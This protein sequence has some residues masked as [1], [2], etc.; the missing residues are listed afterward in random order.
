MSCHALRFRFVRKHN[1]PSHFAPCKV[2]QQTPN[3]I[4]SIRL[5]RYYGEQYCDEDQFDDVE[6]DSKVP[7]VSIGRWHV[8]VTVDPDTFGAGILTVHDFRAR[9]GNGH[10]ARVFTRVFH[11]QPRGDM[12]GVVDGA[13]LLRTIRAAWAQCTCT[14]P[15]VVG[16]TGTIDVYVENGHARGSFLAGRNVGIALGVVDAWVETWP[17]CDQTASVRARNAHVALLSPNQWVSGLFGSPA[18]TKDERVTYCGARAPEEVRAALVSCRS[19][20]QR[21]AIADSW[22]MLLYAMHRVH[23]EARARAFP[24]RADAL[25]LVSAHEDDRCS[26]WRTPFS[27]L[28]VPEL[29]ELLKRQRMRVGGA[30]DELR[31]RVCAVV[32]AYV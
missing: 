17:R 2:A 11:L 14:L 10:C 25:P 6:P 8:I 15:I 29:K 32:D 4:T 24:A 1:Q 16:D 5:A 18:A 19:R 3:D 26:P 20:R 9:D 7:R 23:D 12:R 31:A 22:C 27:T 30:R 13:Q 28:T 21:E